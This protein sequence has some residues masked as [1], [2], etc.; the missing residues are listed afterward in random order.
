MPE[1]TIDTGRQ[2]IGDRSG[3]IALDNPRSTPDRTVETAPRTIEA[4]APMGDTRNVSGRSVTTDS[5]QEYTTPNIQNPSNAW[6]FFTPPVI[7]TDVSVSTSG[8]P[9]QP[10][11]GDEDPY[12]IAADVFSKFYSNAPTEGPQ[13]PVVVGD[14]GSSTGGGSNAGII[15]IL[16]VVG[17][18]GYFLYKR[19][20]K[21]A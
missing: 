3:T 1:R 5:E 6:D 12:R 17:V 21:N 10:L 14:T 18:V 20:N 16:L 4:R 13:S 11:Y 7:N 2:N 15:V 19:Y 9:Q 8:Q